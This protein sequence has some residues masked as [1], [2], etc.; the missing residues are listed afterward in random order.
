MK[1]ITRSQWGA[2]KPRGVT[3]LPLS[4]VD[5][6]VIHYSS[7]YSDEFSP[8]TS[9]VRGI[10]NYHMDHNGWNDIAYN[11]LVSRSGD[12]FEGRGFGV[13]SA[14]TLHNN[15][16]TIAICFLGTDRSGRDDVTDKGRRAIADVIAEINRRAGRTLKVKGHR[17]F[18]STECPGDELYHW[19]VTGG[20]KKQRP[21]PL[22]SGLPR[23]FW[24][25]LAWR[26]GE[27][28]FKKYGKANKAHRPKNIPKKVP[29]KVWLALAIFVA[30]RKV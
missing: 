13:M 6:I 1:L 28:R 19:V 15:D 18:V 21:I 30:N 25:W 10:Q 8:Y 14:A 3:P 29:K 26:L 5:T 23:W 24:T 11:F 27:G 20:W 2:R 22:P 17:D 4:R 16:H 12:I 9:R 7:A